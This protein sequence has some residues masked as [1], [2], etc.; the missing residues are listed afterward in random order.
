MRSS[1]VCL[2]TLIAA[3]VAAAACSDSSGPIYDYPIIGGSYNGNIT[4][5]MT[6]DPSLTT[7]LVPGIAIQMGDPDNNGNFSGAFQFNSGYTGS[8]DIAG[9]FSTNNG[10]I[11]WEQFGDS[12]E[13]LFYVGQFLSTN[14]PTCNFS[15]ASFTLNPNGGFDGNGYL[16]LA[17]T[18]TGIRCATDGAG[19]SDTTAMNVALTAFNP[20]PSQKVATGLS[21]KRVLRSVL[22]DGIQTVKAAAVR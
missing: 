16:N 9:Y 15:G 2:G 6:G 11:T 10:T 4:Y 21:A 5:Q 13:P 8:G 18:Y 22:R 19:D 14:Y 1:V 3:A 20:T 12:A 7:P 17:G